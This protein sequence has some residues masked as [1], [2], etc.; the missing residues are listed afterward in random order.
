MTKV[1]LAFH[2]ID[3][4]WDKDMAWQTRA[5]RAMFG[6]AVHV[7]LMFDDNHATT[8]LANGA[9]TLEPRSLSN[10]KKRFMHLPVTHEQN[11]AMRSFAQT[12][13]TRKIG[14]NSSGFYRCAFKGIRRRCDNSQFFCSEYMTRLLQYAGYLQGVEPGFCHP[15]ML[16]NMLTP[17]GM[18]GANPVLLQSMALSTA[19]FRTGPGAVTQPQQFQLATATVPGRG[20][21]VKSK[22]F[23]GK[24]STQFGSGQRYNQI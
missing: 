15:T 24:L 11:M 16:Y 19:G 1:V 7:D 13:T 8:I 22:E 4:V 6:P 18:S 23:V 2:M 5:C 14:F 20:V 21:L 9:V 17:F 10:Q 12:C 3:S